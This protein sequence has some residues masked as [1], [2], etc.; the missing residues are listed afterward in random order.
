MPMPEQGRQPRRNETAFAVGAMI[1]IVLVVLAIA[2]VIIL[3]VAGGGSN[4]TGIVTQS[5]APGSKSEQSA[6][7]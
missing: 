3:L 6:S 2:A 1:A 5:I 7:P 4:H